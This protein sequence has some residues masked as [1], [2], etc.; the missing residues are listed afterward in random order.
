MYKIPSTVVNLFNEVSALI[1]ICKSDRR[2]FSYRKRYVAIIIL[3]YSR[4]VSMADCIYWNAKAD[5]EWHFFFIPQRNPVSSLFERPR[6]VQHL[7]Y[8]PQRYPWCFA[9]KSILLHWSVMGPCSKKFFSTVS[10][11]LLHVFL[12]YYEQDV[13]KKQGF[14]FVLENP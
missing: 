6:F 9:G 14:V 1:F 10:F 13:V 12:H 11:S 5:T 2:Y 4:L 7:R 8:S 3:L